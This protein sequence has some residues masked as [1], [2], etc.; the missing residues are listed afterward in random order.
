MTVL[1]R[2]LS[3]ALR[4]NRVLR[5]ELVTNHLP[6][7]PSNHFAGKA[8]FVPPL[9]VIVRLHASEKQPKKNPRAKS[10]MEIGEGDELVQA[11]AAGAVARLLSACECKVRSLCFKFTCTNIRPLFLRKS[12][13][14]RRNSQLLGVALE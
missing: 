6:A 7:R 5:S 3:F 12:P 13:R 1:M 14:T 11:H 10:L 4:P 2:V 8:F 9:E